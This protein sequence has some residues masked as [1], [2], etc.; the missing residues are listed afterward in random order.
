MITLSAAALLLAACAT[1]APD[2]PSAT[3]TIRPAS[4]SQVHGSVKFIQVGS[5]VRVEGEIAALTPGTHGFHIHEKGDCSAADAESA[6]GHFNPQG[7]KHGPPHS[8]DR[9]A[10][11]L[12]NVQANEYGRANV[13][14]T[15]DGLAVDKG[16]NGVIGRAV[17]VHANADDLRTDPT[18][19]A[20]GRVGCGVIE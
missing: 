14:F 7:K 5:R 3:A 9:H 18:G 13:S 11:D 12:G 17:I 19:N 16:T 1:T 8:S 6:G 15:I 10:G 4:G 2:G 20:G